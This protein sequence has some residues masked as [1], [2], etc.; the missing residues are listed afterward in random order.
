MIDLN[1]LE[2]DLQEVV[3]VDQNQFVTVNVAQIKKLENEVE[4]GKAY[5]RKV[6]EYEEMIRQMQQTEKANRLVSSY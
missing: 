3:L 4:D 6:K 5:E 2:T 1:D